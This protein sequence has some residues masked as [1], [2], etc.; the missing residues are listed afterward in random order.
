[1]PVTVETRDKLALFCDVERRAVVPVPTV[2]SIYEV[3]ALLED[4]GLGDYIIERTGLNAAPRD[5]A[6]WRRMVERITHPHSTLK[7]AVVGKYIELRDAYLSVKESLIHAGAF[8]DTEVEILWVHS[9]TIDA[10]NVASELRGVDAIVVPG[11]FVERGIEGKVQAARYAREN[12]I[13]YLG[14]C[15]GMQVMVVEAARSALGSD[16]ANSTEFDPETPNPVISML[17]EQQ[18]IDEKGGTMRLGAYACH[19]I[20]GSKAQSAYGVDEIRER[21]R[22][23]YEFNNAYREMLEDFGLTASGLS[24]DGTLV[25][26][27][28][29]RN[30]P[31]MVGTQFHPE[32]RSRPD[33]PHPL[34]RELVHAARNRAAEHAVA[35]SEVALPAS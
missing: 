14:L 2:R 19:L 24:P 8:F 29:I 32:F 31:F 3:P 30:H 5:L 20:P 26:V 23:R 6:D 11:G 9:E 22:H 16:A 25:E 35:A 21:H 28:E 7:V 34:F 18:G 12:G 10:D 15:L 13:P 27:C 4:S 33:R 17:T 1:M